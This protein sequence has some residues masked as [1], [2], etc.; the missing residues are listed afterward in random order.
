M[1]GRIESDMVYIN[2]FVCVY[3]SI[4]SMYMY[5]MCAYVC[6]GTLLNTSLCKG[7]TSGI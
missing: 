2:V 7:K 6:A 3:V 1:V 5:C 4:D